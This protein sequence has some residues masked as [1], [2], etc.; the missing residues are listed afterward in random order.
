MNISVKSLRRFITQGLGRLL[1]GLGP[2]RACICFGVQERKVE[3]VQKCK[4][5]KKKKG[6]SMNLTRNVA[7]GASEE[8]AKEIDLSSKTTK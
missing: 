4:G 1:H 5:E 2:N 8:K 6:L 3:L 7:N